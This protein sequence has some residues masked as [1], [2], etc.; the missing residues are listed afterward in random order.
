M[1]DRL[2]VTTNDDRAG[3][4][5]APCDEIEPPVNALVVCPQIEARDVVAVSGQAVSLRIGVDPGLRRLLDNRWV[6]SA[7][8]LA[9]GP[10]G[11]PALWFSRRFSFA[12]KTGIT[13]LFLLLT[14]VVPLVVA[15]YFFEVALRPL[16]DAMASV[17]Q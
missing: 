14:A 16:L 17:R 12:A 2:T 4:A 3:A 10:I 6:I 9:V 5:I 15:W 13:V 8:L 1:S 7:L 11:L